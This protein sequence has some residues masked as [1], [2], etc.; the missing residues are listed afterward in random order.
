MASKFLTKAINR[1][2][3]KVSV[4]ELILSFFSVFN[5]F[6]K[7]GQWLWLDGTAVNFV[8]WNVGEPSSQQNEHCVEMYADSGYWNNFYCTTYKG[9]ICKKAKSKCYIYE[10][11]LC[12]L[13]V[14]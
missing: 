2:H 6:F 12:M 7:L 5:I 13:S 3:V 10:L 1:E 14:C 4:W 9:Y 11:V 8:N